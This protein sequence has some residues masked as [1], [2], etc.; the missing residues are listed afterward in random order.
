MRGALFGVP[1]SIPLLNARQGVSRPLVLAP[2]LLLSL[3]LAACGGGGSS[4]PAAPPVQGGP[5]PDPASAPVTVPGVAVRGHANYA[6]DGSANATSSYQAAV[7]SYNQQ[8]EALHGK[9]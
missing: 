3:L 1:M 2:A 9:P 4:G 5:V 7:D 6:A 8:G